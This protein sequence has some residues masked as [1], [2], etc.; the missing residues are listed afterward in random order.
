M[1]VETLVAI[2]G[3]V[4]SRLRV[5]KS[6]NYGRFTPRIGSTKIR[7]NDCNGTRTPSVPRAPY[8]HRSVL[9]RRVVTLAYFLF[10]WADFNRLWIRLIFYA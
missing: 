5:L 6:V 4:V 10:E 8:S 7:S 2:N 3:R 9:M 1:D